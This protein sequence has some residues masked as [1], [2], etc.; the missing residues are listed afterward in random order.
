MVRQIRFY[1]YILVEDLKV[2]FKVSSEVIDII[3]SSLSGFFFCWP[4]YLIVNVCF[5]FIDMI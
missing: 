2:Q 4:S 5:K 1:S 3:D